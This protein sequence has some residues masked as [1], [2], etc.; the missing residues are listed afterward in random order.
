M[1]IIEGIAIK[2]LTTLTTTLVKKFVELGWNN[3]AKE[4][5]QTFNKD[6]LIAFCKACDE[7]VNIRTLYSSQKDVFIDDVY[8]PLFMTPIENKKNEYEISN[9][10]FYN[11]GITSIIGKAGQGKSTFLRKMMINELKSGG[12]I[13]IFFELKYIKS[14]T[15][16]L[17]QLTEWFERH[18]LKASEKTL[19]RLF[20][21]GHIKLFLDGFDEI[22]PK[23]H[24]DALSKIKDISRSYPK[25]TVI[26][27]TRPDTLITTEPFISNFIVKDLTTNNVRQLFMN[28]SNKDEE[29]TEEAMQQIEEYPHIKEI[30]KTP[31]LAILLFITYRAWSKIPDNLSDFYKKIF[32][33]LLTHHDSLKPGKKIDRGIDIPL[34]DHQIEDIFGI[35]CFMTFSEDMSAFSIR[36]ASELMEK[37]L[38]TECYDY[39][40]PD[41]LV[42]IIKKCTGILCSDG[43]DVL[44]F[45]HKSLQEY[46]TATY[47]KEQSIHDKRNFYKS[48]KCS[49]QERKYGAVLNFLKAVDTTH[50]TTYYYI[51]CFKEMFKTD[52][53][54]PKLTQEVICQGVKNLANTVSVPFTISKEMESSKDLDPKKHSI[55]VRLEAKENTSTYF[56]MQLMQAVIIGLIQSNIYFDFVD[57]NIDLIKQRTEINEEYE[58]SLNSLLTKIPEE[59]SQKFYNFLEG[60]VEEFFSKEYEYLIARLKK[61]KQPSLLNKVFKNKN[62]KE[63]IT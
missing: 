25:T 9:L 18:N 57:E 35:F 58:I 40:N 28:I 10:S 12:T 56:Y 2:G 42:D 19:N 49:E 6:D 30:T 15:P 54:K 34:N 13:P 20:K 37:A 47:I 7:Y 36:E 1:G 8:V 39:V 46:Y 11:E 53:V 59:D 23:L 16:L 31:I 63:I 3:V 60:A 29:Q 24:D 55:G 61:K 62:K 33:T 51:P 22:H 43:Y 32:I 44:T 17:S 48:V 4:F 21:E 26:V 41:N 5:E 52:N 50:Y 27:T 45:S 14:D 38:E